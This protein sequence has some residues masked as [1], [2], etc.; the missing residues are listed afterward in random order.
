MSARQDPE[1]AEWHLTNWRRFMGDGAT[2]AKLGAP[3]AAAGFATGGRIH[4]FDDLADQAD[5]AAA[6]ATDS[7]LEDL[8]RHKPAQVAA[9]YHAYHLAVYRFPRGNYEA[10]LSDAKAAV[11]RELSARG[12]V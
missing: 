3:G 8:R 9:V 5:K 7:I 6:D 12:F 2:F 4:S 11:W 1:R 10:L